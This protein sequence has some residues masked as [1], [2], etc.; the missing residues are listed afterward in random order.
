MTRPTVTIIDYGLGNIKSVQQA[1]EHIGAQVNL[2]SCPEEIKSAQYLVLPG[3]GAFKQGMSALIQ[4]ELIPAIKEY[5]QSGKPL[6]GICLGMQMLLDKS[7]E[8]GEH[9]GLGL[10]S[11]TVKAID[12]HS[13]NGELIRKIPHIGWNAISPASKWQKSILA[14]IE[15]GSF[16]YFVH[17][18][19]AEVANT[20]HLL[21]TCEYEGLTIPAAIKHNNVIGLQFHPEKSAVDGLAILNTFINQ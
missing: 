20:E 2:S 16:F 9:E 14:P 15:Q 7:F 8:H 19:R 13:P 1:F 6:M 18:F 12:R 11:G 4:L 5:A 21:A 10:I 3:V 17:S